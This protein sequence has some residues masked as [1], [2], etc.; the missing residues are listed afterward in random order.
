MTA[1]LTLAQ[2]VELARACVTIASHQNARVEPLTP[3]SS[4]G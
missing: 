3:I 1:P 4:L 2:V